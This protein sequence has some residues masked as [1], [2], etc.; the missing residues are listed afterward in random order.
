MKKILVAFFLLI[1]V[2]ILFSA[3]DNIGTTAFSFFRTD[4]SARANGMAG[5]YIGLADDVNAMFYNP[6]GLALVSNTQ[7]STTYSSF[8]MGIP[9]GTIAVTKNLAEKRM[10]FFAQYL[11][12][13]Q[14]RTDSNGIENGTFGVSDMI[15]GF[16]YAKQVHPVVYLGVNIK[17]LNETIDNSSASALAAD[18]GIIHQTTNKQ[19]KVGLA[20]KNFGFQLSYFTD[21]KVKE[22]FPKTVIVGLNYFP[23]NKLNIL[24]DV[25]KPLYG[26][27]IAK[28]GSE[29]RYNGIISFRGGF[30]SNASNWNNGGT[31]SVLSGFSIGFGLNWKKYSFD[32][33]IKSYGD[34]GLNNQI[35]L[36][37]SF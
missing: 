27:I 10:G 18:F 16:S 22:R 1:F 35:S 15:L 5:A 29:Y 28:L 34:L 19:L 7:I 14:E 11:S 32:Y 24:L 25:E 37:Y 12:D 3:N 31:L 17:Y 30:N 21:D 9:I 23:T 33:A 13:E 20:V 36:K 8:L 26:D 4:L 2:N 6:A